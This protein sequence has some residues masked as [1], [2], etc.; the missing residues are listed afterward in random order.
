MDPATAIASGL[1]G[2]AL[3][4]VVRELIARATI[5]SAAERAG[6][7]LEQAD[8]EAR[9]R[10]AEATKQIAAD[11]EQR[12]ATLNAELQQ[13]S[14]ELEDE[15]A[16]VAEREQ[17]YERRVAELEQREAQIEATEARLTKGEAAIEA[18][19]SKLA[20]QLDTEGARLE[21]I[22]RMTAQEAKDELKSRV[23]TE[24]EAEM[25]AR[26]ERE[27]AAAE[28][29]IEARSRDLLL[30]TIQRLAVEHTADHVVSTVD[31]PNDEMKG[32]II[33][34]EGRNIRA[35]EQ[36]TGVDVIIDD[37][38]GVVVVSGFDS[39]RREVA[40]RAME[41]LTVDGRIHPARIEEVVEATRQEIEEIVAES[42]RAVAYEANVHGLDPRLVSALGRLRYRS[43]GGR[44]LLD[45]SAQVAQIA[46]LLAS[47]LKLDAQLAR[48]AGLLHDVGKAVDHEVEGSHAAVGAELARRCDEP[49]EVVDAIA[50][51]HGEQPPASAIAILVQLANSVAKARPA[52][53]VALEGFVQRME[54]LE[55]LAAE[56]DGV[57]R[58]HAIRAGRE[59]RV[60]VDP[61]ELSDDAATLLCRRIARRVQ[62]EATYPNELRVTLLR[63]SRVVEYSL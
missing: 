23:A 11:L 28:E 42:G 6:E 24:I 8:A 15:K 35:F 32:R 57:I 4:Y 45:H 55:A 20:E 31:I 22:A 40:R 59:L 1:G 44:T 61:D 7:V 47:E 63:E 56:F 51:H 53:P 10:V 2:L 18:R 27:V 38:P 39:L 26:V 50:S 25:A 30:H 49:D 5:G 3:G 17:A 62:E 12:K 41:K 36:A 48:R 9:E 13:R 21:T 60:I 58:A 52:R 16:E 19:I 37:T 46:G 29:Q 34:R 33:G 54:G 43:Q 14:K